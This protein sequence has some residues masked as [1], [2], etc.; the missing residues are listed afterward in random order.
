M[1]S[2]GVSNSLLFMPRAYSTSFRRSTLTASPA[3][4]RLGDGDDHV[5]CH[6]VG[7]SDSCEHIGTLDLATELCH[8]LILFFNK[9]P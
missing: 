2:L 5:E 8:V 4:L 3:F 7:T 6:I 9:V 1:D